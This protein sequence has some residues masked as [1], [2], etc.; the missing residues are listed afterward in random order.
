MSST[1]S[2]RAPAAG[3]RR[4]RGHGVL[5]IPH[6]LHHA[7][8]LRQHGA[9]GCLA[10]A[11]LR[12]T[13]VSLGMTK[14]HA[15]CALANA[16]MLKQV[17]QCEMKRPLFP[18]TASFKYPGLVYQ[19]P[20]R[21]RLT[22]ALKQQE[23]LFFCKILFENV[24][25]ASLEFHIQGVT[26]PALRKNRIRKG[27][28]AHPENVPARRYDKR[29]VPKNCRRPNGQ[30]VSVDRMENEWVCG[31]EDQHRYQGRGI[32]T[33]TVQRDNGV[34]QRRTTAR[35]DRHCQEQQDS[36]QACK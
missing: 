23:C 1:T 29:P 20:C 13:A 26:S 25:G 5:A 10:G 9:D 14:K 22:P 8:L 3:H 15:Q 31:I 21:Y 32:G 19:V 33:R 4:G 2:A 30:R 27:I 7:G 18:A 17:D 28:P 12:Q 36:H 6:A 35:H 34:R 11:A 24:G 16:A